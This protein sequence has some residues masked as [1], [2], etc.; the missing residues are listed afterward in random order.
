LAHAHDRAIVHRDLKPAN[1][2]LAPDGARLADFGVARWE[3]ETGLPAATRLTETAAVIGT[4]PYMSPEQRR[5]AAVDRRSDLFSLGVMLYE[6]I[7]GSVPQG[8]FPAPSTVNREFLRAIDRLVL[9]LLAPDA[10]RRPSSADEAEQAARA[11][12]RPRPRVRLIA[13]SGGVAAV[14]L[15][16]VLALSG[17]RCWHGRVASRSQG[18]GGPL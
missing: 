3:A 13:A 11:A 17:G 1:V 14:A 4:L 8:A 7:T 16:G 6:A 10:D 9:A 12:L 15:G 18:A 2:L 5:G